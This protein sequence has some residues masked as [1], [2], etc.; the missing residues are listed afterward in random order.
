MA[1][2]SMYN[3]F[4]QGPV[5]G[6]AS[7]DPN[8][9]AHQ[10]PPQGYPAA[11]VPPGPSP[12]Q[13]GAMYGAPQQQQWSG[14]GVPPPAQQ[15]LQP[16]HGQ[17]A[18][19]A[20]PMAAGGV[21]PD[22]AMAG[23]ASQMS[24]LGIIGSDSGARTSKKKH[25]HAHHEIA[26]AS[27]LASQSLGAVPQA[28]IPPP[29]QF[30]NTGLNQAARPI[31]PAAGIPAP[32]NPALGGADV[33][34]V[35]TQG[36]I[37]PEQIPSIPRSRDLP[38]QYYFNHV[39]PTME[40]HLPPPAAV[41]F[42]A[43]DQGNSS[44]KYARLT[45]NNIPS[46]S[47]FLSSTA[48]PLGMI[49]QP[50]ARLDPGEQPI[51]VL[52]FGDAGPPRCRRCRT[53]I[54]PFM[55]F[56]S[57][58]N[59]FVCN[60][61]TF[62][63]DVTADY[64]API[65]PSG[66]R[67]DRMQRPELMMGTVEF[68]VPKDY[69]NKEPV[70]LQW[71]FLID[72]SLESVNRGFLKGVCKGI[73]EALYSEEPSENVDDGS[74][75]RRI[76]EGAKVGIVTYDKE[77]HFYNLSAQL[78]Q[79]QMMVMTDLEEP[80]VP[81]S[82]GL[83]VDPYESK[84][85]I[86]SLLQRIP[87]IFSRVKNPQPALLPALNAALAALRPTGGKIIGTIA[88]LPTWGPG[89]LSL[90][91]DPKVHG[92][93]GERKLFTTEHTGWR[94]TAGHLAEAGIGVDMFIAAPSGTYMDVATIGHVPEV[95]GG[96]TF[97]YPNFHAPRDIRKLSQE[98]AHAVTRETG[99]Q[100]LMKVRCSNGLQVSGYHGNFVQHTF[101]A[102]LEIGAIDADKAIG[103]TF[104]YDGKLN[105][106]LDAHFQAAL[107]Y[108][109]ANGQRRV[110]CINT[111]A[112]VNEG[113][114]ETMKFVDQDAV[115]SMIAKEAAS[116]TVDKPLKDI[117]ASVTE[118]SVDI[119]SGYRKIFSGSHPPGQ[120]VLPENLKEFSMYMLSLLKSRA[121]KGGQEASDRRIHDMRMLRS[122]G[123]TELSLYL[124]P[125]IVPIHNMQPTDGFPNE[126]GQLQVPPSLRASF[127]KIEEG[128]AYLVDNGQQ[129]LL[130][131]HAQVSPNLLEDLFGEGQNSLQ[132][133]SPQTSTIPVLETHLNAQ[134]RNLLQYLST[135]RG[136]KAVTIQLARQ[137]LDGAE[138]EFARM[139]VEDR[140]EAQSYVDW[141]VHVH[142]QINL[143]LA[144]QRKRD[145]AVGEGGIT[146][147]AGLRAPYW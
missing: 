4:G 142:R 28:G 141:L 8:R 19:Q 56:R 5:P 119:F 86:A 33:G 6:E 133:L 126:Q 121:L 114:L 44:P 36:K 66:S 131:L 89:A 95:T 50:L 117:R 125:R 18:Y 147:L 127:S 137:G 82:E 91:D 102:D 41:P 35:P 9:T 32:V 99:Y 113:G 81:L 132:G 115:V 47:D 39:Y 43:H 79:A 10:V 30:L 116:K 112:A 45:L 143:E 103:V 15:P 80:F 118:K 11:G 62:P 26:G 3:S 13:P 88:S 104:S 87:T 69:W 51:P 40:R 16:P 60:M 100:A 38:A 12:P 59:K 124:Y 20:D 135:I 110:R 22:P 17:F 105:P 34:S 37:D 94:E 111:V 78:D 65:D 106:K 23:L 72:V 29:S 49:L 96:E 55:S 7:T 24:G 90:R 73:M 63:N 25:R 14:Y 101:G 61:C 27:T 68:L 108:T 97:F 128:G 53:Y 71:L 140:N 21:S 92:T 123:C 74:A 83:F 67:V 42:V 85:V 107:L 54:N 136:S 84:N 31:S 130:W 76:P 120:L 46:T 138:Y 93:D 64:F 146:S 139:L 48:L 1:D 145:D 70:G 98:L 129:C 144:G 134:V 57:G 2:P 122:I 109:S 77:V 52:D 58:G 75:A